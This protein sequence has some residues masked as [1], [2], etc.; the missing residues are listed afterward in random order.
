MREK[1]QILSLIVAPGII[2]VLRMNSPEQILPVTE[3]LVTGGARAVEITMTTPDA[4]DA[5]RKVVNNFGSEIAVGVGT[6]MDQATCQK[7]LDAGAEFVVTPISRPELI[8][9]AHAADRPILLGAY[10]PTEAQLAYEA[11]AD[12]IKIFPANTLGPSFISALH[13]PL[14]H[15]KIVPTGGV[16][17]R[18]VGEFFRHGCAAVGVGSSLVSGKILQAKDWATLRQLTSDFVSEARANSRF[19]GTAKTNF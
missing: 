2:P 17:L 3:A 9:I 13:G 1:S 8:G 19:C 5:I 4:I 12:M 15:L 14:P 16:E 6:V 18:N 7:A 10:T 11:G